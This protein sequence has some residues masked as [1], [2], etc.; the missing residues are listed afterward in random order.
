MQAIDELKEQTVGLKKELALLEEEIE[1]NPP[2][3]ILDFLEADAE[4]RP[5]IEVAFRQAKT[6]AKRLTRSTWYEWRTE[7]TKDL[8]PAILVGNENL[9]VSGCAGEVELS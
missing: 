2:A 8:E 9:E 6:Y 4:V 7:W 1:E 3:P 5:Q